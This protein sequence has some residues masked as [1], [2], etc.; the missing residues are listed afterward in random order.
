MVIGKQYDKSVDIWAIGV[1]L[2]EILH[3]YPPFRGQNNVE[4][5]EKIINHKTLNFEPFISYI[6]C[7][8]I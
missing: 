1:L 6:A 7:D 3:G 4:K 5:C 8:L 2:Y